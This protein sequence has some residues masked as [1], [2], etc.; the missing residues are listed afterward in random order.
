MAL[1][2]KNA[3][4]LVKDSEANE[5]LIPTILDLLENEDQ[6][7]TLSKNFKQLAKPNAAEDLAKIVTKVA[8]QVK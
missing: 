3:A 2:K 5:Q 6:K 7:Q 4:I 1:V 8:Q